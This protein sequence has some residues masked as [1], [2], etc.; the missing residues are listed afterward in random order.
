MYGF[1][2]SG[3]INSKQKCLHG[4][5]CGNSDA[6]KS[7]LDLGLI[8]IFSNYCSCISFVMYKFQKYKKIVADRY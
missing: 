3:K 4:V 7:S 1:W 8:H 2:K 5:S 6:T